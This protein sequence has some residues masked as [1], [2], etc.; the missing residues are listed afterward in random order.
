MSEKE[1]LK[2][3]FQNWQ[4]ASR[5]QANEPEI[6]SDLFHAHQGRGFF[7]FCRSDDIFL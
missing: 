7:V 4:A 6:R 1:L 3:S 2:P 5:R